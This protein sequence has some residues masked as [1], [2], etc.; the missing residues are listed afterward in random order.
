M[1]SS[2]GCNEADDGINDKDYVED[3][4]DVDLFGMVFKGW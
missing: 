1:G 4:I 2:K 3:F